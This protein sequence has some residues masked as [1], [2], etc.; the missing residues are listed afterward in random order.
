MLRSFRVENYKS[1]RAEVELLLMPTYDKGQLAV[2]V[3][4]IFG[5]NASGKSSLLGAMQWMREAVAS[6]H[7]RWDPD[8]GIPRQP[9]LLDD[10]SRAKPSTFVVELLI[11][12]VRYVYGF[13]VDDQRVLDEWLYTYPKNRKRVIFEREGGKI[14]FGSTV[15]E[16]R[17]RAD[18]L[19]DMTRPNAL[20]VS[21]AARSKLHAATKVAGW[22]DN[23]I[24]ILDG[25]RGPK[26][27]QRLARMID[28]DP[29]RAKVVIDL[30]RA[31]DVG[32]SG[33][34]RDADGVATSEA[35]TLRVHASRGPDSSN[36]PL[37][38]LADELGL[39]IQHRRLALRHGSDGT[40]LPFEDESSGTH[41][42]LG[43]TIDVVE[44]LDQGLT[45]VVDEIDS[46][47]HPR[48]T[49]HLVSLFHAADANQRGAQLI[50]A[51]HDATLLGS[52]AGEDILR[53]DEVWFIE[54][55]RGTGASTLFA[56]SDFHPRKEE[57]TERR[58]LGGSYGAV[59]DVTEQDFRRALGLDPWGI[60]NGAT[61]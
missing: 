26:Q 29:E 47:L 28:T 18:V 49:A 21:V 39:E 3:A 44:A 23:G 40:S 41:A 12:D 4:G 51:T 19:A 42:W 8:G 46:S 27:G 55:E 61:A 5:A 53:R 22:F 17:E 7:F 1:I 6:S 2:P 10:S 37:R 13:E 58:Y 52:V 38:A 36:E 11:D 54:K 45:L 15:A 16:A 43:L 60:V 35:T 25:R 32:I 50:F 20:L 9:F 59:P 48:L 56:L 33:V 30:L 24:R 34:D 31:A 57:N 14:N